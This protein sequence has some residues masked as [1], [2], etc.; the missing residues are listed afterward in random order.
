AR[1][2]RPPLRARSGSG[3]AVAEALQGVWDEARAAHADATGVLHDPGVHR[4]VAQRG[5]LGVFVAHARLAPDLT[6]E[7]AFD[8]A[9]ALTLRGVPVYGLN[10][11]AMTAA[12][13]RDHG[14]PHLREV[15]LPALLA[16]EGIRALGYTEPGAGS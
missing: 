4:A 14:T 13:I 5:W 9:E 6:P 2:E 12:L 1:L 11:T 7:E 3:D 16:G 10:T 15:V 8:I